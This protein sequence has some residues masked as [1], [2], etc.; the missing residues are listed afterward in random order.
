MSF[1]ND[2]R[3]DDR[4]ATKY[5]AATPDAATHNFRAP[6]APEIDNDATV[7]RCPDP[8]PGLPT[9]ADAPAP[10]AS[11]AAGRLPRRFGGYELLEELGHGGMGVVYRAR[12]LSPER[13]VALKVIRSGELAGSEAV[14]RFRR[15]ADEAARLDHPH[16]VPVYEVGEQGGLHFFTMKL[17]EGGSL[18]QHLNRYQNDPKA[19]ARLTATAARAVHYAHQRQ[20]LHRDLKPGN[21]LLDASGEPHV[22]DF[23]LAKRMVEGDACLTRSNAV[24]GTPEYMAP[25]QARSEKRLT[26]ATDVYGLG[27]VLYALLTGRPPFREETVLDTLA[28][29]TTD[30][31]TPPRRIRPKAP[32]DLE[33]ICLKCLRKE[34]GRRY[35]SASELA[36][37]L[38]RYLNDEPIQARA[39]TA[40]ERAFK[41]ARRRPARAALLAVSAAAS[42]L[43]VAIILWHQ[44]QMVRANEGLKA[45]KAKAER[46]AETAQDNARHA[47]AFAALLADLLSGYDAASFKTYGFH[48]LAPRA[49]S[50]A[51][52]QMLDRAAARVRS[53]LTN[54]PAFQAKLL[55]TL[56]NVFRSLGE[57]DKAKGLLEEGLTIRRAHLGDDHLDTA[58]S[59]FHIGW[60]HH[61]LGNYTEA[62]QFYGRALAIQQKLRGEDDPLTADTL[63]NLAWLKA[64]QYPDPGPSLNR[65][66]EAERLFR[67]V[68]RIRQAQP[69]PNEHD[70]AITSLALAAVL[71]ARGENLEAVGFVADA[72]RL[73]EK[74]GGNA[75][76]TGNLF[77]TFLWAE[78]LR[79]NHKYDEAERL[80]RQV[81]EGVRG[82]LGDRHPITAMVLGNLAGLLRQKGEMAEAERL[83]REALDIGRHGPLHGHP[84]MAD[85]D[86]QLADYVRGREGGKE[87]EQ[88]YDEA[89]AILR[90]H[91]PENRALYDQAVGKL[92]DLLR[93]QGRESEAEEVAKG[94]E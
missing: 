59:L 69:A 45:E 22:A 19:A 41:W 74:E 6:A 40:W 4:D 87:A 72:S 80:H 94:T 61:D 35:A 78:Q 30:N 56:G 79:K 15:E 32:T 77:I 64:R 12:Q 1:H 65:I 88:L 14:R 24:V 53:D 60:L 70:V 57:C 52:R 48:S 2:R 89:V 93:S 26:T 63:F 21:I 76:S 5:I 18:S 75:G 23:G 29:V 46:A 27:S 13:L 51:A 73:L 50:A 11:D 9:P 42:L 54:Q 3:Q 31:P 49:G 16:I 37:D 33:T 25:E 55:D 47:E 58:M 28:R 43:L 66:A 39:S 17:V 67:E 7:T 84:M 71:F 36:E 86:I 62:E 83:I 81:L 91:L 85:A 90:G 38:E 44:W 8:T 82:Q 34:P 92:K 10:T 20:L 68:L